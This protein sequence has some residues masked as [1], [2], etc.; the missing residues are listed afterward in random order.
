MVP[1]GMRS[2]QRLQDAVQ[3]L[4][5]LVERAEDDFAAGSDD[6]ER[7][8]DGSDVPARV[9]LG[10]LVAGG[11]IDAALG[12][13]LAQQSAEAPGV[14]NFRDGARDGNSAGRQITFGA[15]TAKTSSMTCKAVSQSLRDTFKCVTARARVPPAVEISTPFA[16]SFALSSPKVRPV[17]A[18]SNTTILVLT[19]SGSRA[20]P[21]IF[22]RPSAIHFAL[23]WSS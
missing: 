5:A 1:M 15:H 6:F 10:I 13:E 23:A 16:L 21:G 3:R 11:K 17:S 22:A 20:R 7:R 12:V 4:A 18:I 14:G 19:F 2:E 9:A 8:R